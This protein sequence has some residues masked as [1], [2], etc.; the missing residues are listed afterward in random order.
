MSSTQNLT[1]EER[2]TI[3]D[4]QDMLMESIDRHK[5]AMQNGQEIR[6]RELEETIKGLREK[7]QNIREMASP[8]AVS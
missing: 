6:A 5:E 2:A 3:F 8:T 4:I 1:P 7:K